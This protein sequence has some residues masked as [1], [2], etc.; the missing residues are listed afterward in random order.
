MKKISAFILLSVCVLSLFCFTACNNEKPTYTI[1]FVSNGGTAIDSITTDSILYEPMPSKLNNEFVAWYNNPE[2]SGYPIAFPLFPKQNMTLYAK[3][4]E[5][6][7]DYIVEDNYAVITHI[8]N[9]TLNSDITFPNNATIDGTNYP[10]KKIALNSVVSYSWL[11]NIAFDTFDSLEITNLTISGAQNLEKITF[12]TGIEKI[13][14]LTITNC[15]KLNKFEL[16]NITNINKLSVTFC[17]NLETISINDCK[18]NNISFSG[19]QKLKNIN[20][21]NN[22]IIEKV[23]ASAFSYCLNLERITFPQTLTYIGNNAFNNCTKLK[24]ICLTGDKVITLG[25]DLF[26]GTNLLKI[27]VNNDLVDLYKQ[28]YKDYSTLFIGI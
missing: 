18:V 27:K 10:V 9:C 7:F 11:K 6:I 28:Q 12:N 8:N 22:T 19:N 1:T 17:N 24:E 3:W 15:N 4:K 20:F 13:D 26:I 2:C 16:T 14:N 5:G 21:S 25:K 23:G